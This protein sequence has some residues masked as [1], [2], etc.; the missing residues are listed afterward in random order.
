MSDPVPGQLYRAWMTIPWMFRNG[1]YLLGMF[2]HKQELDHK[3]NKRSRS[4]RSHSQERSRSRDRD[5]REDR[6]REDRDRDREPRDRRA[7]DRHRRTDRD[8]T[9]EF[10]PWLPTNFRLCNL[11][12]DLSAHLKIKNK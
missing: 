9:R 1:G 2:N 6:G 11:V 12:D 3:F 5:R 8:D 7:D 10:D 4:R